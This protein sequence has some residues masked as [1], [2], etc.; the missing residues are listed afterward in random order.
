ML[1]T[2]KATVKS[3]Q[4]V[5]VEA[6]V[7][8]FKFIMDEPEDLGGTNEGMNPVEA[9]LCALGACQVIVIKA[10]AKAQ[11]FEVGDVRVELE[12]DL[13]P[14]GFS[15]K[16]PDVRNGFQEIRFEFYLETEESDERAE[17]FITFVENT[18]PVAD[19]LRTPVPQI[20]MGIER[21]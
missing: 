2:S 4:G 8:G 11:K 14:D 6:D 16:N 20:L 12:G 21:A 9:L 7:R 5:K 18:C 19:M 1:M 3:L 13:D 15:G 17:E 10:F